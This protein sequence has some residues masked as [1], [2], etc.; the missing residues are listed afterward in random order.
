MAASC[1]EMATLRANTRRVE[2]LRLAYPLVGRLG[3]VNVAITDL[4]LY[5]ARIE[6]AG[7]L[8]VGLKTRLRFDWKETGVIIDAE[9]VRCK[10]DRFSSGPSGLTVYHSGLRFTSGP[11]SFL[12]LREVISVHIA[13]ALEE[14]KAN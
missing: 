14:Q 7:P 6:H 2:R 5:G 11:D 13:Q 10:V 1:R 12:A 9:V 3:S 8:A 4:S